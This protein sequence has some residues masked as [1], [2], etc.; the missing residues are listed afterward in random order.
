MSGTQSI[1]IETAAANTA[2]LN[3][4]VLE[5]SDDSGK[6][7]PPLVIP[8]SESGTG[9]AGFAVSPSITVNNN[10]DFVSFTP[11]INGVVYW[12]YSKTSTGIDAS[13]FLTGYGNAATSVKGATTQLTAGQPVGNLKTADPGF[14]ND[15]TFIVI[16]IQD[17]SGKIQAPAILPRLNT[18]AGSY[19]FSVNPTVMVSTQLN[20]NDTVSFTPSY[21]GY[22]YYYYTKSQTAPND[23]NTFNSNYQSTPNAFRGTISVPA[24]S[25]VSNRG[26]VVSANANAS[27]YQYVTFML[28]GTGTTTTYY[29]PITVKRGDPGS[30]TG[31]GFSYTPSVSVNTLQDYLTA[32][33]SIN[34][35]VYWYYTNYPTAPANSNAFMTEHGN[36]SST[37]KGTFPVNTTG[38][39]AVYQYANAY[40]FVAFMLIDSSNNRYVPVVVPRSGGSVIGNGITSAKVTTS[41]NQDTISVTTNINGNVY[42]YY[43]TSSGPVSTAVFDNNFCAAAPYYGEILN[44]PAYSP[45]Y[46]YMNVLSN[47]P[48]YV[49]FMFV[50]SIG[51]RYTPVTVRR[52]VVGGG[53]GGET[54]PSGDGFTYVVALIDNSEH[55]LIVTPEVA[56]SLYY[57]ISTSSTAPSSSAAYLQYHIGAQT[58]GIYN[59][60][61]NTPF[62]INLRDYYSE[63]DNYIVLMLVSSSKYYTP[64]PIKIPT[65]PEP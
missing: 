30:V 46:N 15:Y 3:Y 26:L 49:V 39:G 8:R 16:A 31:S 59:V 34:G 20:G 51:N 23:Y 7:Y 53:S 54:P 35:T 17:T 37:V 33:S 1:R 28:T 13:N 64:K 25:A 58:K 38:Y 65:P 42:Y 56:G 62:S 21:A 22:V 55:Y 12:Y 9:G 61:K 57:Y 41:G 47:T 45:K 63:N 44:I 50:D 2:G 48:S 10:G 60:N 52:T 6:T 29:S 14:A 18:N 43:T 36:T 32:N 19:G 5:L 4:I 40:N 27:G 11:A 24:N